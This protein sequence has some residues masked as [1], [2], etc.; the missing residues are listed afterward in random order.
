MGWPARCAHRLRPSVHEMPDVDSDAD[1]AAARRQIP[2][3]GSEIAGDSHWLLHEGGPPEMTAIFPVSSMPIDQMTGILPHPL[4]WSSNS[5]RE[6]ATSSYKMAASPG[7]TGV[8][9]N[10]VLR[11]AASGRANAAW[12]RRRSIAHH[13]EPDIAPRYRNLWAAHHRRITAPQT[14]GTSTLTAA[15]LCRERPVAIFISAHP[16]LRRR[17]R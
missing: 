17:Q 4:R 1:M 10:A 14:A 3:S 15:G 16:E 7:A 11:R 5:W 8:R 6:I 12:P 2:E 9:H 13:T